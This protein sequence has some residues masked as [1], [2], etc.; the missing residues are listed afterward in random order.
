GLDKDSAGWALGQ[1]SGNWNASVLSSVWEDS[2]FVREAVLRRAMASPDHGPVRL[3]VTAVPSV[4]VSG[5]VASGRAGAAAP[6]AGPASSPSFT[7]HDTLRP[8]V[9]LFHSNGQRGEFNA[10][11]GDTRRIDGLVLGAA[12][13]AK[14]YWHVGAMLGV[15]RS[16]L[17]RSQATADAE[18][19]TA[20]VGAYWAG[21]VPGLNLALGAVYSLHRLTQHRQVL[22]DALKAR[23]RGQTTQIFA[24]VAWPL[25]ETALDAPTP[26]ST[27]TPG[28]TSG[29][30]AS[31][32]PAV[33]PTAITT[34]T[35]MRSASP[36]PTSTSTTGSGAR[37]ALMPFAQL[38]WVRTR[39]NGYTESG[40]SAA[41]NVRP[42]A[43]AGWLS[44]LGLRA[45]TIFAA[46][47]NGVN[48]ARVYAQTAWHHASKTAA[49]STQSFRDS[50]TQTAFTSHGL[51]ASR[52]AWSVQVGM[53]AHL[54]KAG[55][56][57]LGYQGRFAARSRD[58]GVAGWAGISF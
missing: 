39:F 12:L 36:S 15:Q 25:Y 16:R 3:R 23:H 13:V 20:H 7:G 53:Q 14:T 38:A 34:A 2:R 55:H 40:G 17:R 50:A 1:L 21:H 44:T 32:G 42:A 54:G 52:G 30:T 48:E 19:E 37:F 27:V 4:L 47:A 49:E 10:V 35:A 51:P 24:E 26:T 11:P 46:P 43:I 5:T 6:H 28:S 56:I 33:S 22:A 18:I 57:G 29:S 31:S 8:W 9:E 58:Q 41:L 45:E